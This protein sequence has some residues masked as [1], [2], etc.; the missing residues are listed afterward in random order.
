MA[1]SDYWVKRAEEKV[2]SAEKIELDYEKRMKAKFKESVKALDADIVKIYNKYAVDNKLRYADAV[3]YLSNNDRKEFQ[4]DL[5]YYIKTASDDDLRQAHRQ[6][7]QALSARARVKRIEAMKA[8]IMIEGEKLYNSIE[9][10]SI[11][12]YGKVYD[13]SYYRTAHQVFAQLGVGQSFSAPSAGAIKKLM[14]YPWNGKSYSANVWDLERGFVDGLNRVLTTG[15]IRGQS[16]QEMSRAIRDAGLG[17]E[18]GSKGGD[19]YRAQRLIRTETNFILNQSTSDMY[20][21][22]EVEEYEF[23]GTLDSRTCEEC[24][25]LD[26]KHF[27]VGKELV[28]VNYPPMHPLCRCTTIPYFADLDGERAARAENGSSYAVDGDMIYGEWRKAAQ[29]NKTK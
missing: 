15:L 4:Q 20:V 19:L 8:S 16:V 18:G 28:G 10:D 17:K 2:L 6:E 1:T 22:L 5:E 21:E 23:L 25:G 12:M 29:K 26:S 13:D 3:D 24:G 14:E 9:S 11:G 7:L 27:Q